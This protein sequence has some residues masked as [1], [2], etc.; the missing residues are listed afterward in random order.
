MPQEIQMR[1][2]PVL[3]DLHSQ[4]ASTWLLSPLRDAKVE[5]DEKAMA[6]DLVAKCL[7]V[8]E[9]VIDSHRQASEELTDTSNSSVAALTHES[10]MTNTQTIAVPRE[11]NTAQFAKTG[12]FETQTFERK[13]GGRSLWNEQTTIES[14]LQVASPP[15]LHCGGRQRLLLLVGSESERERLEPKVSS[16]HTGSLTT[17]VIPGVTPILVHEAQ[18]IPIDHVL[19]QLDLVSGGNTQVSKRLHT[20]SDVEWKD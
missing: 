15:L 5:W 4:T 16:V 2:N 7:P 11:T 1:F 20:R 18:Q 9:S 17:V 10:E 8:I 14:A 13:P 6:S 3:E 19:E 12:G